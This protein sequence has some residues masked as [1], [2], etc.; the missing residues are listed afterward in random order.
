[1]KKLFARVTAVMAAALIAVSG[2]AVSAANGVDV[3]DTFESYSKNKDLI[4][5]IYK[6]DGCFKGSGISTDTQNSAPNRGNGKA[7]GNY[8]SLKAS[9]DF[10]K[11]PWGTFRN[12]TEDNY[13][14]VDAVNNNKDVYLTFWAKADRKLN[15]YVSVDIKDCPFGTYVPLTTEWKQYKL[16]L[17][18]LTPELQ[19]KNGKWTG[20][21]E[22]NANKAWGNGK[23][24]AFLVGFKFG[25]NKDAAKDKETQKEIKNSGNAGVTKAT[26]WMDTL[27]FEGPTIKERSE[28]NTQDKPGTVPADFKPATTTRPA[29]PTTTHGNAKPTKQPDKTTAPAGGSVTTTASATGSDVIDNTTAPTQAAPSDGQETVTTTTAANGQDTTTDKPEDT[30]MSTGAK[31]G[32]GVGVVVVLAGIGAAVYFFVIKK[33]K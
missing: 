32:I 18:D 31:V 16:K 4:G 33:K 22:R 7:E 24:E 20:I 27:A 6:G 15:V 12:M 10:G 5:M 19:D 30:G 14:L 17:R 29:A 9:V 13:A 1:M 11:A 3:V 23:E 26:Y 2:L 21:Y 8:R 25:I 28:D